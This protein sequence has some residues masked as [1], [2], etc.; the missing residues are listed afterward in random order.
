MKKINIL[1]WLYKSKVNS[2]GKAPVYLRVSEK[3]KKF[4]LSTGVFLTP[5]D[6][7]SQ[8]QEARGSSAAAVLANNTLQQLKNRLAEIQTELLKS[9]TDIDLETIRLKLTGQAIESKNLLELFME[10]NNRILSLVGKS[11][12][13]ATHEIYEITRKE[14]QE[15]L[16]NSYNV[17]DIAFNKLDMDFIEKLEVFYRVGKGNQNNTVYKKLQRLNKVVNLAIRKGWITI[18]PFRDHNIK[19]EKKEI[20]FLT[21][22]EIKRLEKLR[23]GITRLE[24]VRKLFLL[25]C[26]TGL[27]F[28]ELYYLSTES[29]EK[30]PTGLIWMKIHR[31]KTNKWLR[32]PL[33]PQAEKLLKELTSNQS[34]RPQ[35]L[36]EISGSIYFTSTTRPGKLLPV[37][38]N[39]KMNGYLKEL[40]DLAKIRKNL[41]THVARKTFAT[42]VTLLAG[43]SISTVSKLLGHSNSRI[44]EE[45]YS[46]V[47]DDKILKELNLKDK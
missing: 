30:G 15:F 46:E 27:A 39:Q 21:N 35:K 16:I 22:D 18:N 4:Q 44:T 38:T 11:Y 41:T 34:R 43:V 37:P 10:H 1:F 6:W 29:F 17:R 9:A 23:T 13:P 2:A 3:N 19:K 36:N 45:A 20:V 40:S 5:K 12:S 26:Y 8:R 42:T 25:S 7:N 28:K 24:V 31:Q 32:V 33:L 47:T 14:I